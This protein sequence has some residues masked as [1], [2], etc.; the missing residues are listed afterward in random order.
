MPPIDLSTLF[1]K[2]NVSGSSGEMP[3]LYTRLGNPT[4]QTLED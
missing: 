4:R 3:F 1:E 2:L